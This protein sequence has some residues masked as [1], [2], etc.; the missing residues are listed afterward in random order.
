MGLNL[1]QTSASYQATDRASELLAQ[2]RTLLPEQ[3]D[4]AGR[5]AAKILISS[6]L[7]HTIWMHYGKLHQI[8]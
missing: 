6:F 4:D 3:S 1:Y 8:L 7:L 2:L 5:H